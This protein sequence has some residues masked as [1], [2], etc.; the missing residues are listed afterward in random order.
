MVELD[1][2][3][4][5]QRIKS[6]LKLISHEDNG[7]GFNFSGFLTKL[8][9]IMSEHDLAKN[10]KLVSIAEIAFSCIEVVNNVNA[11]NK[12]LNSFQHHLERQEK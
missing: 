12:V 7:S 5:G 9:K 11:S 6:F 4:S 1:S 2:C 3:A 10:P 8:A